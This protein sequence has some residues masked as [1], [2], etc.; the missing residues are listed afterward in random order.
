MVQYI[1][2][3]GIQTGDRNRA[4]D[5]KVLLGVADDLNCGEYLQQFKKC[6]ENELE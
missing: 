2:L 5:N 4:L 1:Y 3:P 6:C